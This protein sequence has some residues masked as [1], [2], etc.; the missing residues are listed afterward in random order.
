MNVISWNPLVGF[1]LAS[2]SDDGRC[3][4]DTLLLVVVVV[5]N[6]L[7]LFL[8]PSSSSFFLLP[9]SFFVFSL[10]NSFKIWDLRKFEK[11]SPVAHFQFH[12]APITSIE[13]SGT[14][15]SVVAT[16]SADHT[17]IVWDMSLE[18]QSRV[19]FLFFFLFFPSSDI[20]CLFF[21]SLFLFLCFYF[22]VSLFLCFFFFVSSPFFVVRRTR[23]RW[24]VEK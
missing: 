1:L 16:S 15:D 2:G 12:R 21:F 7:T 10:F 24:R 11:E 23:K 17:C 14:E 5:L 9:S 4:T 13:W 19:L 6:A 22:F 8:L 18:V 20:Q 3:D